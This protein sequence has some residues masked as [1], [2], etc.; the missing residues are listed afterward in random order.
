VINMEY[1]FLL[2]V[3][4]VSAD[5]SDAVTAITEH[6]QGVFSSQHGV[7]RLAVPSDGATVMEA[8]RNLLH[9]ITEAA[10]GLRLVRLDPDLVGVPDI[11]E[12]TGHTRQNVQQ[13]VNGERNGDRPFPPPEGSAGRSLVWRWAEVNAWLRPLGLDD[14]AIRP[15]R[16]E[17]AFLDVALIEWN[18]ERAARPAAAAAPPG[19]GRDRQIT[20]A[21]LRHSPELHEQLISR[22]P[23]VTG[24]DLAHWFAELDAGP[25][26]LRAE[27]QG[28]WL[29]DEYG[30][31]D[32]Y[33]SAI[34][35]QYELHREGLA[36]PT[37]ES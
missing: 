12:R 18:E 20:A 7:R 25:A 21:R 15:T 34:A 35:L 29:A 13:W 14:Q 31:S 27:D 26:F 19:R 1:Q 37:Q 33:A 8:I 17:S 11:A 30:L 10:P 9:L 32:G 36:T 3:A 24:R 22:V 2:V 6:L 16:E 4:D 23:A 28:Q 5:D